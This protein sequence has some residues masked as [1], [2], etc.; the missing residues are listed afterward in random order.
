MA[1]IPQENHVESQMELSGD[2]EEIYSTAKDYHQFYVVRMTEAARSITA[3]QLQNLF[4]IAREGFRTKE[5]GALVITIDAKELE[6]GPN[7][8]I[9]KVGAEYVNIDD[10][11][12]AA[13]PQVINLLGS[14]DP[15]TTFAL[16]VMTE[17]VAPDTGK[18]ELLM[19]VI[20]IDMQHFVDKEAEMRGQMALS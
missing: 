8:Q 20:H 4:C 1:G 11:R 17:V 19:A 12:D 5:R 14:Y 10:F 18:Q 6:E 7:G 16:M 13:D 9:L 3:E 2:F 15:K